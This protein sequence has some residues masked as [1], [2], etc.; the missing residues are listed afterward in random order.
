MPS[1]GLNSPHLKVLEVLVGISMGNS[2]SN[3]QS[4]I[5]VR[6]Q[7]MVVSHFLV[8]GCPVVGYNEV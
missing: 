4:L 3:V 1:E 2:N 8:K 7:G 5:A 6:R